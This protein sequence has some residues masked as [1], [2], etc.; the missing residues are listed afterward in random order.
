MV[1]EGVNL[2]EIV[3]HQSQRFKRGVRPLGGVRPQSGKR[4]CF[5]LWGLTPQYD[6]DAVLACALAAQATYIVSGDPHLLGLK[7]Y[8]SIQII[9]PH[10]FLEALRMPR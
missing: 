6:D 4:R 3:R 7:R 10:T 9:S 1:Q 8:R 2:N 5:S